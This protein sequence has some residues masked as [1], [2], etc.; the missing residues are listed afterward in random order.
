MSWE[1]RWSEFARKV[2]GR[3]EPRTLLEV[4]GYALESWPELAA[5]F[6]SLQLPETRPTQVFRAF[7]DAVE[8][9]LALESGEN[10]TDEPFATLGELYESVARQMAVVLGRSTELAAVSPFDQAAGL[11]SR[12]TVATLLA[13]AS[14]WL[15]SVAQWFGEPVGRA[16]EGRRQFDPTDFGNGSYPWSIPS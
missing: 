2:R 13:A 11:R 14:F 4:V 7:V 10:A 12:Y 8:A 16:G 15:R 3:G 5:F 6:A 1:V 9:D